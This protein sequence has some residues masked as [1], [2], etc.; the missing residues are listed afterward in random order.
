MTKI[1]VLKDAQDFVIIRPSRRDSYVYAA[2]PS[3][4]IMKQFYE[5]SISDPDNK[6][7][8]AFNEY[9]KFDENKGIKGS[10][11]LLALR[12][13]KQ[14][15]RSNKLWIPGF[16]EAKVLCNQE[17]FGG[18]SYRDYGIIVYNYARPNKQVS[19]VLVPQAEELGLELPLIV[20][21]RALDY[22]DPNKTK[23]IKLSLLNSGI[24]IIQGKEA[25]NKINSLDHQ[26]S[27]S[28]TYKKNS[29]VQRLNHYLSGYWFSDWLSLNYSYYEGRVDWVCGEATREILEEAHSELSE[30][31]YG[32]GI[33]ELREEQKSE[34]VKFIESLKR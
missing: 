24:G 28:L 4:D 14:A 2:K 11:T 3:L 27:F 33:R 17:E 1:N 22:V 5:Q 30:R 32:K 20:P 21:F 19:K 8:N 6:N 15:L 7:V 31:K 16:L 9:W 10:S 25:Q 29:G 26:R 12:F 34:D 23:G 13:D 18:G